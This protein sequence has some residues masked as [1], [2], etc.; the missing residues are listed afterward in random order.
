M[1]CKIALS[2]IV[3]SLAESS[4]LHEKWNFNIHTLLNMNIHVTEIQISL[5]MTS[6]EW[7]FTG[8][9]HSNPE[10]RRMICE[11]KQDNYNLIL[12]CASDPV[13]PISINLE[14]YYE[15]RETSSVLSMYWESHLMSDSPSNYICSQTFFLNFDPM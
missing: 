5:F 3:S 11:A 6:P 13:I 1:I 2:E 14:Y 9:D 10:S 15:N 4:D 7:P 12:W 8:P